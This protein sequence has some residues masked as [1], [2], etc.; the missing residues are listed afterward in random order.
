L[1]IKDEQVIQFEN[2]F[3]KAGIYIS[4][5]KGYGGHTLQKCIEQKNKYILLVNWETLDAHTIGFRES[6]QYREWKKLLR[7]Y[8]DP[9]P[10]V[11][12]YETVIDKRT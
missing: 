6:S 3:D 9:F 8:Y 2:D 7:H 12:H 5:I 4:S 11:E 1:Y 10:I